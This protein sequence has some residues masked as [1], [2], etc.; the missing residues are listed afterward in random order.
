MS[1]TPP[2]LP[3]AKREI[4]R[5][6]AENFALKRSLAQSERKLADLLSSTSWRITAPLRTAIDVLRQRRWLRRKSA[7]RARNESFEIDRD[8]YRRWVQSYSSVDSDMRGRLTSAVETLGHRPL[9]SVIMPSYNIDPAWMREAIESVRRQ[10]Y[11][12]W[13]LCISDDASTLAG[14]RQ[15]IE[16]QAA[17]DQRIRV[18]FRDKNGH[19]SANSNT[20]LGLA[21]GDYVALLDADDVLT[22]DAL[23]WVAHEIALDPQTDMIF[24]DEDK[25]GPDGRRFD[26]YFKPAWNPALMVGQNA[27]C[28]LGV[29]RR[30]LVE[31]V[32]RFREGLEGAQDHDLA[33]RCADATTPERIRHIP[34]VLYHWRV[35]AQSTAATLESKPYAAGAGLMTVEDHLRR[36]GIKAR[37]EPAGNF[38]QVIDE[39]PDPPPLV[40]IIVPT[41]LRNAVT[42][43]CLQS[44]LGRTR[45]DNFELLVL[46]TEPDLAAGRAKFADLLGDARVR[47]LGYEEGAFNY[48]R[49]NNFGAAEARGSLLCFLNDD[50]EVIGED[51]LGA[52]VARVSRDGVGAAGPMLYYPSGQIQHA[53]VLLGVGGV[54]DHAFRTV[55]RGQAGYFS[56]AALEQDYSC[57]TAACMLVRR[58]AFE[59]T[60]GFDVD[61]PTAF[62]DV[63]F[64]I[65]L[66]RSGARIVW[67]PAAELY[68]HESLTY[69]PHN[70]PQRAAQFEHDVRVMSSRWKQV[71]ETD[72]VY[73]PNLSLDREHQFQLAAPPRTAFTADALNLG[74]P[75]SRTAR[76]G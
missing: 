18:T 44:L 68:H 3:A 74:K 21:T 41:T 42:Q 9:I 48:S 47:A 20:A 49:V 12:H 25:I 66:R 56:R 38:Y 29:Y 70:S 71:L 64:C 58:E 24:S 40:S 8:E 39:A 32:G 57:V 5:L 11:P 33:L 15:L 7:P 54:A 55:E 46:A 17:Q 1:D 67:T 30:S 52:L 43:R 23:F 73:N 72:P 76:L 4:G 65:R 34:R 63:D 53:G 14:V 10:I 19:I 37:A 36:R 31:Q 69:G 26:P 60:G 59:Q 62:N 16:T 2:E 22:E 75:V 45:Y 50:V 6:R 35:S 51:W 27:F 13:E 61:L 28:H